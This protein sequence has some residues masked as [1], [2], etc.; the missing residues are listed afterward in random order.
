MVRV[1]KQIFCMALAVS[2]SVSTGM[3]AFA[4]S[5]ADGI[6]GQGPTGMA[7][8]GN[9]TG[10]QAGEMTVSGD[11]SKD[12]WHGYV[13]ENGNAVQDYIEKGTEVSKFQNMN[14][15]IDWKKAKAS[16][17]DFVMVRL[18]YGTTADPYFEQNV[19]GAQ[20]A[21]IKVGVY[22][23]STA[24]NLNDTMAEAQLTLQMLQGYHLQYP[25]AY[26]VE[27]NSMLSGGATPQDITNMINSYCQMVQQA[28]FYPIVYANKTWIDRRMLKNQIPYDFWYAQ[29]PGNKVYRPATGVNITIWQSSEKGVINGIKGYVTTELSW[30]AY[31]GSNTPMGPSSMGPGM[32][33]SNVVNAVSS[34]SGAGSAA[35]NSGSSVVAKGVNPVSAGTGSTTI[36]GEGPTDTAASAKNATEVVNAAAVGNLAPDNTPASDGI[37]YNGAST[38][39]GWQKN[40]A[41]KWNYYQNGNLCT[42]F[43]KDTDGRIY[44]FDPKTYNMVFG[45]Q[46]I[47]GKW[48]WFKWDGIMRTG[49]HLINNQWYYMDE[50]GVTVQNETRTINGTQYSFDA[51]GAWIG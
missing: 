31:N 6:I 48:Y 17:L 51:N 27:V 42:G 8:T 33:S 10:G 3:T 18:A 39:N 13:Y 30:K 11:M 37:I 19:K 44:Y 38:G 49:W 41:G 43:F 36:I 46:Q 40:V 2:M 21:G 25:V 24:K 16:G 9:T 28:G 22:L 5:P 45:W 15:A 1:K 34:G 32:S 12:W 29:Y 23:C 35:G 50:N 26:D 4:A 14:G 20:A 47:N 7:P